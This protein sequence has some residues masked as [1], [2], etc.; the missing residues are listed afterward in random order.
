[1]LVRGSGMQVGVVKCR[2]VCS[3]FLPLVDTMALKHR[4]QIDGSFP[5]D[6]TD[7]KVRIC[8]RSLSATQ[9]I[10]DGLV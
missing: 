6:E 1:M 2:F 7:I 4:R 10:T 8:E 5:I 9:S 3:E